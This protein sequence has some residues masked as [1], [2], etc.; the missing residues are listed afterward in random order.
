MPKDKD[1]DAILN[2]MFKNGRLNVRGSS[3]AAQAEKD[4]ADAKAALDRINAAAAN[5]NAALNRR[6]EDLTREANAELEQLEQ[7]LKQD[8]V[9]T[10]AVNDGPGEKIEAAFGAALKETE[11]LVLGQEEFL[12]KLI[13]ALR[14]PFVSG[15]GADTPLGRIA[16]LGKRGT[17]RHTA[18]SALT[19]SL[20]RQGV[21]K[22]PKTAL[23]DL[24]RYKDTDGQKLFLQDLFAG[25]K[26]G[27]GV[28]IFENFDA[29]APAVR[30]SL[31]KLFESGKCP[32]PGR[33]VEQKG[34]L[35]DVGTALAAGAISEISAAG[36]YLVLLS[37][38]S[39]SSLSDVLGT[40][41]LSSLDDVCTTGDFSEEAL[42][43]IAKKELNEFCIKARKQL[44]FS[45]TFTPEAK[46]LLAKKHTPQ[47]G[48]AA[49][50]QETE[51]LYRALSEEKL[52]QGLGDL[53]GSVEAEDGQLAVRLKGDI[54]VK[55][56]QDAGA[57]ARETAIAAVKQELEEI[58][59]LKEV[60]E[61][62]LSLE[63]NFS[64][65]QMRKARGMKSDA[66]SMHM[67]FTGNPGTGKTTVAR[68]VARYLKAIGV[69]SGGQLVEVTRADLV[70]RYVGHTAPLTRQAIESALG[71][72]LFIDEAYSLYRGKDDSFGLEAID[73]LV[74]GMEDHREDVVV[75]LAGYTYEMEEFL[76]ANS[77]LKSRFPNV[78]EFPDY[79]GEELLAITK[80]IIKGKGYRLAE[81]CDAPLLA[82]FEKQQTLGD[83]RTNGNGRMARNKVEEAILGCARRNMQ[84]PEEERDL[85]LL[86]LADFELEE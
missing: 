35:V 7:R 59:G 11:E 33:Y 43:A 27:A 85:E 61:Y 83:P 71:G 20:G 78:I 39:E 44:G 51:K 49:L 84:L 17:G 5:T 80:S 46:A 10:S 21:L 79:T 54:I 32:L 8:G 30:V 37:E 62:V 45:L 56:L 75:I 9:E 24:A 40:A 26:S 12:N 64:L 72:V 3:A 6:I 13:L 34:I 63:A 15:T 22:S 47:L 81:E 41:F 14:R 42:V 4:A 19:A 38:K 77:G 31:G 1:I 69:L 28:L 58:V 55:A 73:T 36:R 60:K 70:G 52:Q 68:L 82:Y 76:T 66:P 2:D 50:E 65:Q 18:L 29:A 67:I 53:P 86:T 23:I 48:A 74:K 25:V 16:V 57:A